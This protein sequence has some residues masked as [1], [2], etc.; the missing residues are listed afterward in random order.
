MAS[1]AYCKKTI[2]LGGVHQEGFRFCNKDCLAQGQVVMLAASMPEA[3]RVRAAQTLFRGPCP[4]CDK[5]GGI[6]L[7]KS[8]YVMSFVLFTR[9]GS[10]TLLCCRTC[11]LKKQGSDFGLSLLA[12]W[13]GIPFGLIF[14]PL[15]LLR[16]GYAMLFPPK[17]VEPSAAFQQEVVLRLAASEAERRL[18][19]QDNPI[20]KA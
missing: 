5:R 6:D 9:H 13:W 15:A 19:A 3:D 12:G 18:T 7:Y 2:L 8:H 11:A 17:R 14:T 1:C 16:N 4:Q 10:H 20:A